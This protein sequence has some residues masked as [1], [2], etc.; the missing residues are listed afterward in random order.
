ERRAIESMIPTSTANAA[1]SLVSTLVR[2]TGR[3]DRIMA[4]QAALREDLAF[5]GKVVTLP[6]PAVQMVRD[7]KRFLEATAPQA[8]DPL[9]GRRSEL[10]ALLEQR[11]PG[12]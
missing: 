5:A 3:I 9:H 2:L 8:P 1:L 11:A 6:P 7:L 12:E 10:E 4:E